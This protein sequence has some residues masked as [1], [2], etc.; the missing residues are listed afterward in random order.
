MKRFDAQR[1]EPP[2]TPTPKTPNTTLTP[3]SGQQ[4]HQTH[5]DCERSSNPKNN[6]DL[7]PPAAAGMRTAHTTLD[8][9]TRPARFLRTQQRANNQ[10]PPATPVPASPHTTPEDVTRGA[11]TKIGGRQLY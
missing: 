4:H 2:T 3:T 1:P 7:I 5:P 6:V 8:S 9:K 11:P 10:P